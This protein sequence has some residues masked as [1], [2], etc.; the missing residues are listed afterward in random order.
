M[1]AWTGNIVEMRTFRKVL[2]LQT[3]YLSQ[4]EPIELVRSPTVCLI[5]DGDFAYRHINQA[6]P[7]CTKRKQ[8]LGLWSLCQ[9]A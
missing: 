8:P 1:D 2:T 7:D 4:A 3:S 9:Q 6:A 5:V